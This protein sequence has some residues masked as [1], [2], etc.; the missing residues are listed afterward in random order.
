MILNW[1]NK[2]IKEQVKNECVLAIILLFSLFIVLNPLILFPFLMTQ[3][4]K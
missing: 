2:I 1:K 3:I 4:K